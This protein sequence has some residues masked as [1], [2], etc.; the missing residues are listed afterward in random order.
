[1]RNTIFKNSIYKPCEFCSH[2]EKLFR[3]PYGKKS[4]CSQ[5]VLA[6]YIDVTECGGGTKAPDEVLIT[7][8]QKH[9]WHGELRQTTTVQI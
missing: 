1:M 4:D 7:I 5:W 6:K 9:G 8:L 2:R 3:C